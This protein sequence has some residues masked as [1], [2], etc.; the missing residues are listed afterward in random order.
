MTSLRILG[1]GSF[2]PERR[3]TNAELEQRVD[4]NDAWIVERTGIRERRVLD[5]KLG[6]SDMAVAAAQKAL[7][8]AGLTAQDLDL[9]VI[10]TVTPDMFVPSCAVRVQEKLGAHRA[11]AFDLS[12]ACAGSMV[13]L[14]VVS[15]F[16]HSGRV[17]HALIVGAESMTRIVNEHDRNTCV[18]FGDAA[19]AMVVGPDDGSGSQLLGVTTHTDGRHWEWIH[20]PGGGSAHPAKRGGSVEDFTVHMQGREVFKFAV[21]AL[22]EITEELLAQ[23]GVTIDDVRWVVAHQANQRILDALP[24]RMRLPL[25]RFILTIEWTGNTSAASVPTSLDLAVRD[26]RIQRGDLLLM[27][28]IGAGMAW[29]AALVKY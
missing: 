21:R 23:S 22:C 3:L 9:I 27:L 11:F 15:Q 13:A 5:D 18:L 6:T 2:F 14:D 19:G 7:E 29:S 20:V 24:A 4:T 25:D 28:A 26:G 1:T 16:M 10:A 12:A 17:K 8:A